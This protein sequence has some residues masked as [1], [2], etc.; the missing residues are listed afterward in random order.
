MMR[1][2]QREND[3]SEG[4]KSRRPAARRLQIAAAVVIVACGLMLVI[5]L[6][7]HPDKCQWDFASYSYAGQACRAALLLVMISSSMPVPLGLGAAAQNLLRGYYSLLL[8]LLLWALSVWVAI[9]NPADRVRSDPSPGA[10]PDAGEGRT[11]RRPRS[12]A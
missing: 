10:A 7:A 1:V 6:P 8:T 5:D 9:R 4:M 11:L 3:E 12:G 2:E